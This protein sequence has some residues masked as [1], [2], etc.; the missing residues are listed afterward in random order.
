MQHVEKVLGL[1]RCVKSGLRSFVLQI[2]RW[3]MDAPR[4]GR[5]PEADSDRIEILIENNQRSTTR[6]RADIFKIS[7]SVKL[8]V[9]MK[10]VSFILHTHKPHRSFGQP[11]NYF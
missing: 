7:K 2:S 9:K 3:P 11:N 5:P 6:E 10:N 1:I 8:L 4:L